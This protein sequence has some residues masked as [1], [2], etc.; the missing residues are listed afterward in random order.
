MQMNPGPLST[1]KK[2]SQR[3]P[4]RTICRLVPWVD[5]MSLRLCWSVILLLGPSDATAYRSLFSQDVGS[6]ATGEPRSG[7]ILRIA[8]FNVSMYRERAG[9]LADELARPESKQARA[10]AE[11]IRLVRPDVLLLNEFVYEADNGAL[12]SFLQRYLAEPDRGDPVAFPYQFSAPVNTGIASGV[13]LD[14]DGKSDGAGDCLGYGAYPGQYGM[15]VISRVPIDADAARTFQHVLWRDMPSALLPVDPETGQQYYS[16]QVLSVLPISSKSHW[17]VPLRW[18]AVTLHLLVS[19]PTPPVFDGPEDRNGKRNHDEI[20]LWADYIDPLRNAY[21]VDDR[22]CAGGLA[23]GACFVVAGDLNSDPHDGDSHP[24]AIRQLLE[25]R[26]IN[27]ETVPTS[28]GGVYAS[29]QQGQQNLR[30]RGDPAHDTADFADDG[31]GNLRADYLLP[32]RNLTVV[33]SGV[34]WPA[35]G[36]PGHESAVAASDHRL[37]WID[38]QLGEAPSK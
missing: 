3:L 26:L 37:V 7:Q 27:A 16:S 17:D 21:L 23:P 38:I 18:G 24:R 13:D 20:R 9:Q 36:E 34:F 33:N 31:S 10:I 19:H 2:S 4:R 25:H 30:H 8:T 22:G 11:I 12:R 5:P 32:S 6:S 35:P 29:R 14:R 28:R 15:A 1:C